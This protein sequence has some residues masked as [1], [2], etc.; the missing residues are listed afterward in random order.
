MFLINM[1]AKPS[2]RKVR[3]SIIVPD[4]LLECFENG[5]KIAHAVRR[6]SS[7][8]FYCTLKYQIF[9]PSI[10]NSLWTNKKC[11]QLK[12]YKTISDTLKTACDL[13]IQ[14]EIFL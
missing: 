9:E 11:D 13:E 2:F 14:N 12:K 1:N 10:A 3:D 6:Y 4:S 5:I 8:A 7:A